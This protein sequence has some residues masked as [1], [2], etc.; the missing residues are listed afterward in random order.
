MIEVT[1]GGVDVT[2]KIPTYPFL[3]RCKS[4]SQ[5]IVIAFEGGVGLS[6]TGTY[7]MNHKEMD[8]WAPWDDESFWEILPV[9]TT[10]TLTVK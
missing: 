1:V 8:N 9:G 7:A 5:G 4:D 6:L 10:I 3:A 2:C